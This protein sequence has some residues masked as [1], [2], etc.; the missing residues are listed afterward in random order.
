[1]VDQTSTSLSLTDTMFSAI[2]EYILF[3]VF[4]ASLLS[5]V[6]DA[7]LVRSVSETKTALIVVHGVLLFATILLVF[8]MALGALISSELDLG[9][10]FYLVYFGSPVVTAFLIGRIKRSMVGRIEDFPADPRLIWSNS[11][12]IVLCWFFTLAWLYSELS[13]A[14]WN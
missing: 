9:P 10:L 13:R 5:L 12:F 3:A 2:I 7:W 4:F 1:M 8:I 14:R 6:V 11:V